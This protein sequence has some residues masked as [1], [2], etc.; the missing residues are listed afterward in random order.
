MNFTNQAKHLSLD[1]LYDY[2]IDKKFTI[3]GSPMGVGFSTMMANWTAFKM[4][5]EDNYSIIILTNDRKSQIDMLFKIQKAYE[6]FKCPLIQDGNLLHTKSKKMSGVYVLNYNEF[7]LE[8]LTEDYDLIIVDNDDC[9]EHLYDNIVNLF[10]HSKQLLFNTY[11][12]PQSLFHNLENVDKVTVYSEYSKDN[13]K[14]LDIDSNVVNYHKKI[15]GSFN[16]I[17]NF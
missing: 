4:F 8:N 17:I 10:D 11:D 6:F 13:W 5:F 1:D 15:L 3:V 12:L 14:L 7:P 2:F 9:S 16:P